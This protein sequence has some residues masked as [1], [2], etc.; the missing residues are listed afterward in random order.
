MAFYSRLWRLNYGSLISQKLQV[1]LD[2]QQI[3]YS[4]N[5]SPYIWVYHL[6]RAGASQLRDLGIYGIELDAQYRNA[7]LKQLRVAIDAEFFILSEAHYDRYFSG[8]SASELSV[9]ETAE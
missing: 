9:L 2:Y 8:Y 1:Q 7:D 4:D 5:K 6:L 3:A